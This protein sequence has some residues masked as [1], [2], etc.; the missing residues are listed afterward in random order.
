MQESAVPEGTEPKPLAIFRQVEIRSGKSIAIAWLQE[1]AA[2]VGNEIKM[3]RDTWR[4]TEIFPFALD[5]EQIK[6]LKTGVAE[7]PQ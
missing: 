4:I 6:R 5:E 1:E 2:T 7:T 3:G